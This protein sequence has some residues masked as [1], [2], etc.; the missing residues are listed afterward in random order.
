MCS[1]FTDAKAESNGLDKIDLTTP[2]S[3][4]TQINLKGIF[5]VETFSSL[6]LYYQYKLIKLLPKCDQELTPQGWLNLSPTAL[7]NEYFTKAH[8]H[9]AKQLKESKLNSDF[10]QKCK[11]DL[12][13]GKQNLDPFKVKNF[14]P[15]WNEPLNSQ[16]CLDE[17]I[18]RQQMKKLNQQNTKEQE[19]RD[20]CE[21]NLKLKRDQ[22]DTIGNQP[23]GKPKPS[24]TPRRNSRPSN[25]RAKDSTCQTPTKSERPNLMN[26]NSNST[27]TSPLSVGSITVKKSVNSSP[28]QN[29]PGMQTVDQSSPSNGKIFYISSNGKLLQIQPTVQCSPQQPTAE[30][31][32]DQSSSRKIDLDDRSQNSISNNISLVDYGAPVLNN[33]QPVQLLSN[34]LT[35]PGECEQRPL[36]NCTRCKAFCHP[37]CVHSSMLCS[38]CL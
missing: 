6:P 37:D 8:R 27:E 17:L 30:S 7:T 36:V 38:N 20:L 18:K 28:I 29:W 10:V 12:E 2:D 19:N 1:T 11:A 31:Q 25:R 23:C 3:I 32:S 34:Y 5:K 35:V 14:E 33:S 16:T 22:E 9:W 24:T 21:L 4:L 26:F 13:K 15:I